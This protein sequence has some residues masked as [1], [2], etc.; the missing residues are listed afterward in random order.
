MPTIEIVENQTP[1]R[2]LWDCRSSDHVD[3]AIPPQTSPP[4]AS[5]SEVSSL[6]AFATGRL[7]EL[8]ASRVP[9]ELAH[10]LLHPQSRHALRTIK[11]IKRLKD[12]RVNLAL[13]KSFISC[14]KKLLCD[15]MEGGTSIGLG[16]HQ[17]VVT[18]FQLHPDIELCERTELKTS[19]EKQLPKLLFTPV[20]H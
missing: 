19:G 1:E 14:D 11:L 20:L 16:R 5:A 4:N 17:M 8:A 10:A 13:Y 15:K 18:L 9:F 7:V 12:G 2:C 6:E 3:H